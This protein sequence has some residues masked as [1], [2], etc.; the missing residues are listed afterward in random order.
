M[1][2]TDAQMAVRRRLYEDFEYYAA[3]A[4]KIRTKD[5][6]IAPFVLNRGQRKLLDV[7]ERQLRERGFVR[8]IILKGRQMGVSTMIQ[9]FLYWWVS[10]RRA[11]RAIVLAHEAPAS[12]NLFAMTKR[13]HDTVPPLLR[14]N[15]R[16]SSKKEL[17]FDLLDSSY[18][19]L[20]AGGDAIA[21]SE[22]ASAA[23]LSET[24]FWP[25]SSA[26]GNYSGL[27]DTIPNVPGTVVFNESTA[28]GMSGIF[29]DQWKA[30]ATGAGIFEG[31]FLPWFWDPGYVLPIP[32]GVVW[33]P[34]EDRLRGLYGPDGLSDGHLMFRRSKITEKTLD[35]FKQEYPCN[36]DEAFLTSGRPVFDGVRLAM[37]R[38]IAK[39]KFGPSTDPE[40][41]W[42]VPERATLAMLTEFGDP[43][44]DPR[45][46]LFIYRPLSPKETY[47]IGADVGAGIR[48][49]HSVAQVLDSHRRQVA[50]WRSDTFDPDYFGSVLAALGRYYLDA[51]IICERNNHGILT[52]RVLNRDEG[53]TNLYTETVVDKVSDRETEVVGFFTSERSKPL[54]INEL[55]A[56]IR[57]GTIIVNDA[58]TLDELQ[59]FVVAENGRLEAD[60]GLHDDCV[61]ALALANH[62]N[63]GAFVTVEN[64]ESWYLTTE[65][66]AYGDEN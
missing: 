63:E 52:N 9:G 18:R 19:V 27:M 23:H 6:K 49:D 47:Y 20:T 50:V 4:L 66:G 44:P 45:G 7:I 39:A 37:M 40:Q 60:K 61:I 12:A 59:G 13:F 35:L 56:E 42:Q 55:R 32:E 21:R 5:Q 2:L 24:A 16:Y 38:D 28:D 57:D 62:I 26:A 25:K 17:D 65:G 30:A 15:T 46:E 36:A 1:E 29:Y 14:P 34:E 8:V 48:K 11:Q 54:V 58:V 3:N 51:R 31:V 64:E 53:Y 43:S 10:Q 41:P 33:T 22:T